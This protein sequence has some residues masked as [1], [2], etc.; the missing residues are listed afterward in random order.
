MGFNPL[1]ARYRC[2]CADDR[3][4]QVPLRGA[5]AKALRTELEV[6]TTRLHLCRD[7]NSPGCI[8]T[9][10]CLPSMAKTPAA[11]RG[12]GRERDDGMEA[13]F[14]SYRTWKGNVL[15]FRNLVY[16]L[17]DDGVQVRR[18]SERFVGDDLGI[19]F[20]EVERKR[21]GECRRSGH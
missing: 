20:D 8:L 5:V 11:L 2:F 13:E 7:A 9:V 17:S 3:S 18:D 1:C 4:W 6:K 14:G 15:L 19:E 12:G 10:E 21:F 16:V